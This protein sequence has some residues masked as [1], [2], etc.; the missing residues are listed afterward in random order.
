MKYV[1]QNTMGESLT[2]FRLFKME[3]SVNVL[4]NQKTVRKAPRISSL[5]NSCFLLSLVWFGLLSTLLIQLRSCFLFPFRCCS[6][7]FFHVLTNFE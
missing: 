7:T 4:E 2:D 3:P 5:N 1:S 6:N